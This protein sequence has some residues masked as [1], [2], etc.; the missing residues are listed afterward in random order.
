MSGCE[1]WLGARR[2]APG[3]GRSRGAGRVGAE[4]RCRDPPRRRPD[5]GGGALLRAPPRGDRSPLRHGL[6][7]ALQGTRRFRRQRACRTERGHR[8]GA[9][10]AS[11]ARR[12]P[13]E[14]VS[15]RP[16]HSPVSTRWWGRCPASSSTRVRSRRRCA[17]SPASTSCPIRRRHRC[18]TCICAAIGTHSASGRSTSRRNG[19]LALSRARSERRPGHL[20]A[21]ADRRRAGARGLTAGGS[22]ADRGGCEGLR[23]APAAGGG[24]RHRAAPRGVEG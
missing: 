7:V 14:L 3:V 2:P 8:R 22:G 11:P 6:R 12:H 21:R 5:L 9:G 15:V 23:P 16:R 20:Q 24:S 1:R 18:S 13:L 19:G 10:L 17:S 4:P